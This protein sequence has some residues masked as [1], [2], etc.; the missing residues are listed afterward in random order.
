[1]NL[2]LRSDLELRS[3]N[4][5]QVLPA[6]AADLE[7]LSALEEQ[8][9]PANIT[10]SRRQFKYLLSQPTTDI[11]VCR[12]EEAVVADLVVFRRQTSRGLLG[13]LYSLA[14]APEYRRA[15][16]ARTLMNFG[17][18]ELR[19]AGA[20]AAVLEVNPNNYP[21]LRLHVRMGFAPVRALPDYYGPGQNGLKMK[22]VF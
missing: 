12:D 3:V 16:Y 7:Q 8:C 5:M 11:W 17:L 4:A 2:L 13:R 20:Y 6:Q 21:A 19:R 10:I 14:V 9:F 18:A 1:M 22:L 15:G